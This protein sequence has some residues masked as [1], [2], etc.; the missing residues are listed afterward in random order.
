MDPF[1]EKMTPKL[2]SVFVA[3]AVALDSHQELWAPIID[4]NVEELIHNLSNFS[5]LE[6]R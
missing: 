3:E 1:G 2:F 6:S 5:P 4:K